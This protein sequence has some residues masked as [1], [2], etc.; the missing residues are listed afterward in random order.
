MILDIRTIVFSYVLTDIVCLAVMMILWRQNRKRLAGTGLWVIDYAFQLTALVLIIL[1]GVI[2]DWASIVLANALV[3]TGALL[4][5]LALLQF[6]GQRRN[7]IFN[8]VFLA[9]NILLH[10]TLHI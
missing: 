8:Y 3:M 7:Q 1:R 5:Y 6:A 2:P 10:A 4:G 9:A